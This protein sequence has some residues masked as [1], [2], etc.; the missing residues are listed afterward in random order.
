MY[1]PKTTRYENNLQR[2]TDVARRSFVC[3]TFDGLIM[4]LE[5]ISG[6]AGFKIIRIKNRFARSN[7]TAKRTGAHVNPGL[8]RMLA[9]IQTHWVLVRSCCNCIA[10]LEQRFAGGGGLSGAGVCGE[11]SGRECAASGEGWVVLF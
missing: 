6:E 3:E 5:K 2:V 11:R 10:S 8:D 7:S 4:V 1:W 9:P